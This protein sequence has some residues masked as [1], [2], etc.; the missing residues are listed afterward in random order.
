M[1]KEIYKSIHEILARSYFVFFLFII[2]GIFVSLFYD[3]KIFEKT[4]SSIGFI[5][6]VIGTFLVFWAQESSRKTKHK[7][8]HTDKE[9]VKTGF[10]SGPYKILR[11][12]THIGILIL[13]LGFV[14][15][16]NSFVLLSATIFAF[17][18]TRFVFIKKEEEMLKE[19]YG[20][21]YEEYKKKVKI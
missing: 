15:L 3:Q 17:L 10:A 6:L 12:P 13:S 21:A 19:K 11:S 9:I 7:R 5:F 16:A 18:F 8:I 14:F 20:E 4:Y 2:L 1:P